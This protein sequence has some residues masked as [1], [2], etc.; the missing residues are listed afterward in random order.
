MKFLYAKQLQRV[1]S[2]TKDSNHQSLMEAKHI[3][4]VD[5]T[6]TQHSRDLDLNCMSAYSRVP[7][8]RT[9]TN[10]DS[11]CEPHVW[12]VFFPHYSAH[13][14]KLAESVQ[15]FNLELVIQLAINYLAPFVSIIQI[16]IDDSV[17]DKRLGMQKAATRRIS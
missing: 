8:L 14:V 6:V 13:S 17:D 5:S 15:F 12:Y 3:Y 7:I 11:Q 9:L 1:F 10:C 4:T 2:R 16:Q